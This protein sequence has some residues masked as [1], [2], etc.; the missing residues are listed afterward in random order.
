LALNPH[1]ACIDR[2]QPVDTA[3]QR[4]LAAAARADDGDDLAVADVERDV[5]KHLERAVVLAE[6]IDADAHAR[7]DRRRRH[8]R[9]DFPLDWRARAR[10]TARRTGAFL[11][12]PSPRRNSPAILHV[13]TW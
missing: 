11:R 10:G 12:G 2:D 3:Q 7:L 4:G 9:L 5:A 6:R 13:S 1:L 8:L